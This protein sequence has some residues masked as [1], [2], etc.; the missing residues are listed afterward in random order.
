MIFFDHKSNK[1][2]FCA[3]RYSDLWLSIA[4]VFAFPLLKLIYKLFQ[5][6]WSG[7]VEPSLVSAMLTSPGLMAA[8]GGFLLA[9]LLLHIALGVMMWILWRP[10]ADRFCLEG[11][12]RIRAGLFF[13]LTMQAMLVG[14]NTVLFPSSTFFA[15]AAP[16]GFVVVGLLLLAGLAIWN[17]ANW[18]RVALSWNQPRRR[19]YF[20]ALSLLIIGGAIGFDLASPAV[21]NQRQGHPDIIFIGIDS[22]R[23][24]HLSTPGDPYSITPNI[25]AFLNDAWKAKRAY[26]PLARTFPSWVSILTGRYPLTHGGRDN[27]INPV[28]VLQIEK[29][30]PFLLRQNGYVTAYAIDESRFSNIDTSYG[31][32]RALIPP[33][34][35]ADFLLEKFSDTPTTNLLSKTS[36]FRWMYPYQYRNRA[37]H[38]TY[39][40]AVFDAGLDK[41]VSEADP[42]KPLFL[43]THFELPHWPF[44]WRDSD[45][46]ETPNNASLELKSP[47]HYHKAVHRTDQQFQALVDALKRHGRLDNAIVV[48]LSDHGEGFGTLVDSWQPADPLHSVPLPPFSFHGI[49]VLDEA[50]TRTVIGFRTFGRRLNEPVSTRQ[51]VASLIDIA[52]TVLAL[53]GLTNVELDSDGCQLLASTSAEKACSPD[54]V[55]LTESGFY[56][57]S[58]MEEGPIDEEAVAREGQIYYD[59]SSEGRLSIKNELLEGMFRDKQRAAIADNWLVGSI[60]LGEETN[61]VFANL[62]KRVY[63]NAK[64]TGGHTTDAA[65]GLALKQFCRSYSVDDSSV[66]QFCSWKLPLF[67]ESEG[68]D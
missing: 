4:T 29:S 40:P 26:T 9:T 21:A 17:V 13:F 63:W 67:R 59:V 1:F 50:Q 19:Y 6:D 68:A 11:G 7:K 2:P 48:V 45:R 15:I 35:A 43:A 60:P 44:T 39:D 62:D 49:N 61:F 22:L 10:V 53:A 3:A 32:D 30:L 27:L 33:I 18:A 25:D 34:G 42:N 31:F 41:M 23:P 54:R 55:V 37:A 20:A 12:R 66:K 14:L 28:N 47:R 52:P 65:L 38:V 24:D 64:L 36:F 8:I 46:H 16:Y 51:P 58:M 56:V 57:P 5:E